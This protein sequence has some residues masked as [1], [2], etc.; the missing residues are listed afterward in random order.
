MQG[1]FN[2]RLKGRKF[3]F[4]RKIPYTLRE[5]FGRYELVLSLRTG[6]RRQAMA[7]GRQV[8]LAVEQVIEKVRN[9]VTLTR[10]EIDRLVARAAQAIDWSNEVQLARTGAVFDCTGSVPP[11]ADVDI[12]ETY[13]DEYRQALAENDM[14]PVRSM[15]QRYA[16]DLDRPI[17]ED[18]TDERLLGRALLRLLADKSEA[19]ARQVENE[20]YRFRR[21]AAE[22]DIF[23]SLDFA[24]PMDADIDNDGFSA[25][26]SPNQAAAEAAASSTSGGQN[27][28]Q[29]I[30]AEDPVLFSAAWEEAIDDLLRNRRWDRGKAAHADSSRKLWLGIIGDTALQTITRK[31]A[32]RFRRTVS[33]L[34]EK[35]HR[36]KRWR[37]LTFQDMIIAADAAEAAGETIERMTV[38]TVNRHVSQLKQLWGQFALLDL[39]VKDLPNPFDRLHMAIRKARQEVREERDQFTIEELRTLFHSPIWTGCKSL[40][41]RKEPGTVVIRDWKFWVPLIGAFTGMRREEICALKVDDIEKVDR[42]WIVNLRKS[43]MRLKTPGSPRYVPVHDTLLNIGLLNDLVDG[44]KGEEWLFPDL[45]PSAL[46]NR[47]GEP[48]GKW[49]TPL[50]RELGIYRPEV[51]FHS[52]RHTVSTA[53]HNAEAHHPFIEEIIGHESGERQSELAR[54]TKETIVA[55]LKAT[56]DRLDYGIDFSALFPKQ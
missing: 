45:T 42:V 53:L 1:A 47:R 40:E 35:Y 21:A 43:K 48:F 17:L 56:I 49:F 18:S 20:I 8:W 41:R 25:S 26:P 14:T 52:F 10:A 36:D 30:G 19:M 3:H 27:H 11:D 44:R 54:Y 28:L 13:A 15:V 24:A 33:Q 38:K 12:L 6:E 31:A 55:N 22:D 4:R 46:T 9:D 2:L 37:G 34:P 23:P 29:T 51:V 7:R 50:R 39:V 32:V 16:S 5:R